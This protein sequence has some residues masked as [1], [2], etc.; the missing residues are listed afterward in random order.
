M[1]NTWQLVS[2]ETAKAHPLYGIK[3]WLLFFAAGNL[4]GLLAF[5]GSV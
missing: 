4:L 3:G 2:Q 5:I 1:K